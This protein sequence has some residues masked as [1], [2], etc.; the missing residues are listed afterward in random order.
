VLWFIFKAYPS[1]FEDSSVTLNAKKARLVNGVGSGTFQ[2]EWVPM[3]TLSRIETLEKFTKDAWDA[4]RKQDLEKLAK[5][6]MLTLITIELISS[7][8]LR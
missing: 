2:G 4:K 5:V 8:I 7:I 6:R 1:H 3:T